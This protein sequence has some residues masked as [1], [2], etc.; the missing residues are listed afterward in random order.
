MKTIL[1]LMLLVALSVNGMPM[2]DMNEA[3]GNTCHIYHGV[4][5]Q[6][7]STC[8]PDDKVMKGVGVCKGLLCCYRGYGL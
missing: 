4:Y 1:L 8:S 7:R 6:C 5:G 2:P 3:E